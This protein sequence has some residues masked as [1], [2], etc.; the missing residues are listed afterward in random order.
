MSDDEG[1][2]QVMV[3]A[4]E[5][6]RAAREAANMSLE[7]VATTTR[8]PTR[9]LSSLEAG[10]FAKLP[11]PTYSVGFARSYAAAVGLDRN[12]IGEQVRAEIG[13]TRLAPHQAEPFEPMDPKRTM[14]RWLILAVIAGIVAVAL[15][16]TWLN[17]RSLNAPDTVTEEAAPADTFAPAPAAAVPVAQQPVSITA[18]AEAWVQIKD[19]ATLLKEGV[20]TAGEKFDVPPTATA[21]TLTTGKAEALTIAV[22]TATAPQVGPSATKVRDVSLRP[23]DLLRGPAVAVA[24]PS[25]AARP[26]A[27]PP[28]STATAEPM[29]PPTQ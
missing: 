25:P 27:A 29:P 17:N 6:L 23:A 21:P 9:H 12:E 16:V 7:D 5:R 24:A 1:E 22:G 20:M 4:G 28:A 3:T 8:I 10:E 14:P 2:E 18:T 19:G 13:G 11:A 15:L 26:V